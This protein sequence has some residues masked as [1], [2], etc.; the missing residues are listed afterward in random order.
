MSTIKQ[1]LFE[2]MDQ[3]AWMASQ[4]K[5]ELTEEEKQMA[6]YDHLRADEEM[7]MREEVEDYE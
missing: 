6:V 2:L 7:S 4:R 5:Q 3:D 1:I